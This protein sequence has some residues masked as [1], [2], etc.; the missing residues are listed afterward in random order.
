MTLPATSGL[1]AFLSSWSTAVAARMADLYIFTLVSGEVFYYSGFQTP[2]LA[3]MAA[4]TSP[5]FEFVLGPRFK[6][7]KLKT[8]VGP[9]IDQL[10]IEVF[11]DQDD[12]LGFFSGGALTWQQAF[13][14]G[15]FDGAF[16]ELLRAYI[17]YGAPDY[18][19]YTVQG[20][21]TR[22]YGRVSD[23]EI[24]R[25]SSK[26]MVKSLLDLLTVQMPRRLFQSAC[27]HKFG[28]PGVGMCGYDRVNGLNA[29]GSSTGIGQVTITCG[30]G[31]DQNSIA[32]SFVPS[33]STSYDNGSIVGASGLNSGFMRTIGKISGGVIYFLKPWVFPVVA[34]T[35][36]FNLLPG[37]DRTLATCTG[38]FNNQLR[39]G[40][41][42][43]VPPPESAV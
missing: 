33:P 40:G 3:P 21:V 16:C 9:T 18:I 8:Q 42:P 24:G 10:D 27:N 15:L 4:T 20:T 43:Y 37:C 36:Q 19:T 6:R 38:T 26:I 28:E 1:I 2:L 5:L 17:S 39:Y 12:I 35:D 14:Q 11:A 25:T 34:G 7:G 29:L 31:S 22:F 13:H 30:G 32:T 23:I 41:F